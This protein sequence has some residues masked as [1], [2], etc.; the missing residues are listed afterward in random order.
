MVDC[1]IF[2]SNGLDAKRTSKS[3][4]TPVITGKTKKPRRKEAF[5]ERF[6]HGPNGCP[7]C[8][9]HRLR[10][11][12]DELPRHERRAVQLVEHR[13]AHDQRERSGPAHQRDGRALSVHDHHEPEWANDGARLPRDPARVAQLFAEQRS[14][15][16]SGSLEQLDPDHAPAA[17]DDR[18]GQM[19]GLRHVRYPHERRRIQLR[20]WSDVL[21]IVS[22]SKTAFKTPGDKTGRRSSH[23]K[24][25][26]VLNASNP[27]SGMLAAYLLR[28]ALIVGVAWAASALTGCNPYG[29]QPYGYTNGYGTTGGLGPVGASAGLRGGQTFMP[30]SAGMNMYAGSGFDTATHGQIVAEDMARTS[31]VVGSA[32]VG[33]VT[34]PNGS[35]A[36]GGGSAV[37]VGGNVA[38]TNQRISELAT[39]VAREDV[40]LTRAER[41]VRALEIARERRHT[42]VAPAPAT[43]P[44][45]PAATPDATPAPTA[46]PTPAPPS[47]ENA[48][49]PDPVDPPQ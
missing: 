17:G 33:P 47:A 11:H 41:R 38:T 31:F 4:K 12:P 21:I 20:R 27:L 36:I 46:A 32:Q 10:A 25:D 3:Q 34:V 43:E 18:A 5:H 2:R 49:P 30:P 35:S 26:I 8:P 15:A 48:E 14:P 42:P 28:A 9:L 13:R 1:H 19:H 29:M 16:E 44:Q 22:H 45:A 37:R 24:K 6:A 23:M 7:R 40:R 39:V